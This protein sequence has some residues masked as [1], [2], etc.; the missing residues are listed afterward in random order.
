MNLFEMADF[1]RPAGAEVTWD[2][3]G[4]AQYNSKMSLEERKKKK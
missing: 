1:L 3:E 4:W 2:T